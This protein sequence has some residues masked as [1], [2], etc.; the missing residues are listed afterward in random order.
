MINFINSSIGRKFLMAISAI[1]LIIFLTQ[2]LLINLLSIIDSE[3]FNKASHF[4]GTNLIVQFIL[5]PLLM[6]GIIFHFV[7]GLILEIQNQKARGKICYFRN[8]G[9]Q[10]TWISK[11]MLFSG[12]T[13]LAFLLLHLMDFWIHEMNIKYINRFPE[14]PTRYYPELI[15]KFHNS[16]RVIA[17]IIS[18]VFLGLHLSHGF[19]SALQSIGANNK[20][21]M[22]FFKKNGNWYS[23][24]I[25]LGFS[26]IVL[27]H[28]YISK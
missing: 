6:F 19:Q 21:Y 18:F 7:M 8:K 23:L 12:L 1:F 9:S 24:L 13:I 2:H 3:L 25:S 5:Q 15:E 14:D 11:N 27:Y 22:V 10:T 26:F 20:K 4:M 17:Y 28:H 16:W